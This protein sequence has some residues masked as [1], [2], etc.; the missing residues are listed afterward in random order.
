MTRSI[1]LSVLGTVLC[2]LYTDDWLFEN[3]GGELCTKTD[4]Y[5]I[6]DYYILR[7]ELSQILTTTVVY[8]ISP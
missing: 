8:Y 6:T 1:G 2:R 5:E 7:V 3:L 4:N